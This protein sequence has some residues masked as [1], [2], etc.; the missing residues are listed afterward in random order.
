LCCRCKLESESEV[1]D[2]AT[3]ISALCGDVARVT[4]SDIMVGRVCH[5]IDLLPLEFLSPTDCNR[6][7]VCLLVLL[8]QSRK[9]LAVVR[10]L[11][12]TLSACSHVSL[13]EHLYPPT[14]LS[15]L[16]HLWTAAI[17]VT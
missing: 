1:E 6:L 7:A 3:V 14:L 8:L 4:M 17:Q 16:T 2:A 13:L 12:V 11:N 9:T 5:L 10:L 15:L